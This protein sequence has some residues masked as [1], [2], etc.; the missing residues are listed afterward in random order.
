MIRGT[1]LSL[2]D[3]WPPL[4]WASTLQVCLPCVLFVVLGST[5][6]SYHIGRRGVGYQNSLSGVF[7][8]TNNGAFHH[9]GLQ[10]NPTATTAWVII[11]GGKCSPRQR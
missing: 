11:K 8:S 5:P 7:D 4:L 2:R 1:D 6:I 9:G 3:L 10:Q